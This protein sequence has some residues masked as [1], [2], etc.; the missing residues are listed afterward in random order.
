MLRLGGF[1]DVSGDGGGGDQAGDGDVLALLGCWLRSED[2]GLGNHLRVVVGVGLAH[3]GHVL[4]VGLGGGGGHGH[5]LVA[6]RV[7]KRK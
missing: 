5:L 7:L 3:G 1:H 4:V 6:M 2:L